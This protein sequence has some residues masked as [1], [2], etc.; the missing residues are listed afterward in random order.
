MGKPATR[1]LKSS[2]VCS[3]RGS[4]TLTVQPRRGGAFGFADTAWQLGG[5]FAP[6]A[7]GAVFG[8]TGSLFLALAVLAVGPL[9]RVFL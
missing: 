4:V 8:A 5:V 1:A 3:S 6:I 2:S 9:L 7:A